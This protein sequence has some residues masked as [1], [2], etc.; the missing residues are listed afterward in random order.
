MNA[1]PPSAPASAPP[2]A[3]Q[4]LPKLDYPTFYVEGLTQLMVGF[5]NSR[6][7]LHSMAQRDPTIPGAPEQRRLACELVMPT[8]ALLEIAQNLM[9]ALAASK[10]QLDAAQQDWLTKLNTLN[11]TLAAAQ[12]A[13]PTPP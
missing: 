9:G 1:Q 4:I 3:L 6:L 10:V 5:P 8:S 2:V 12:P 7:I 13:A 11:A